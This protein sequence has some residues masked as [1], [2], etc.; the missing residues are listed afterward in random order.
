MQ[1]S[2]TCT[3]GVDCIFCLM[4]V[5][6]DVVQFISNDVLVS[7]DYFLALFDFFQQFFVASDRVPQRKSLQI[8]LVQLAHLN[9]IS[10]SIFLLHFKPLLYQI[11]LMLQHSILM[12]VVIMIM[13]QQTM[14]I[15]Q[16]IFIQVQTSINI[17]RIITRIRNQCFLNHVSVAVALILVIVVRT[18]IFVAILIFV[19]GVMVPHVVTVIAVLMLVIAVPQ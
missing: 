13:M 17:V 15:I 1:I 6:V 14:N 11:I 19:V 8:C 16:F 7:V 5:L 18:V 2:Q 10:V 9:R 3:V 4:H 12:H